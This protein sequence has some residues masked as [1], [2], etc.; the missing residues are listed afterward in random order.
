MPALLLRQ[1]NQYLFV[2]RLTFVL[3]S[4][5]GAGQRSDGFIPIS[6]ELNAC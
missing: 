5:L 3:D 2:N 6:V 1:K 4:E